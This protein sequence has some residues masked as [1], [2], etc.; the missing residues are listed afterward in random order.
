M[1]DPVRICTRCKRELPATAVWFSRHPNGPFGLQSRCKSCLRDS[2]RESRASLRERGHVTRADVKEKPCSRCKRVL[3]CTAENFHRNASS[4]G[5]VSTYCKDCSSA[6]CKT[7]YEG[8][9]GSRSR[10]YS[11]QYKEANPDRLKQWRAA[12]KVTRWAYNLA[13]YSRGN[14]KRLGLAHEVDGPFIE[15]LFT[16]QSGICHWFS[17]PLIPSTSRRD[18]QH[19][20][21]DRLDPS[22]G[23]TRDN[24]V[25]T[26]LAANAG[27]SDNTT[28]RF[29]AFVTTLRSSLA[30]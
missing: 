4:K 25:L 20:S 9:L 17:V 26:C 27:R 21:L 28:E 22:K 29:L 8:Q 12:R 5:G 23:Y 11:K 2:K 16:K 14:A 13:D 15:S 10:K 6:Y 3:A 7:R 19:P 18:P 30:S 24:V 1:D